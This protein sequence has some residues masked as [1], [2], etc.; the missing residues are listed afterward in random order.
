MIN[1]REK[2]KM[3]ANPGS[4]TLDAL[5]SVQNIVGEWGYSNTCV[6]K[7]RPNVCTV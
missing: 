2:R 1:R 3:K 6:L 4:F 7:Y 5:Q